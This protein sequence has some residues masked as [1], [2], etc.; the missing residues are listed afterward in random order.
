[1]WETHFIHNYHYWR[2]DISASLKIEIDAYCETSINC[3]L[4]DL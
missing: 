2:A 1:M 3:M 4:I